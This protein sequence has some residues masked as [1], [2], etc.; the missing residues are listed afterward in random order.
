MTRG[1][2]PHGSPAS[3]L[4]ATGRLGGQPQA[5]LLAAFFLLLPPHACRV[6]HC[7]LLW[8]ADSVDP[9][10]MGPPAEVEAAGGWCSNNT[11]TVPRNVR[12]STRRHSG[13]TWRSR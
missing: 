13:G 12:V 1:L 7:R 3:L 11:A 9:Q 2:T 10:G 4:L 8:F 5:L 6:A